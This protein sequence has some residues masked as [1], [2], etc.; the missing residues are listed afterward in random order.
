VHPHLY[1]IHPGQNCSEADQGDRQHSEAGSPGSQNRHHHQ[2]VQHTALLPWERQRP[3]SGRCETNPEE[4]E[5]A[6]E[7]SAR[8][9]KSSH[10]RLLHAWADNAEENQ[11]SY[12]SS[13]FEKKEKSR[14]KLQRQ[15]KAPVTK[16]HNL[17]WQR[18]NIGDTSEGTYLDQD[19]QRC[20]GWVAC[21]MDDL[22][23]FSNSAEDHQKHLTRLLEVLS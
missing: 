13:K 9:P 4:G 15:E 11:K 10:V 16:F 12:N 1:Q 14:E 5:A 22:I 19:N 3:Q 2:G 20:K 8:A 6:V 17:L 21:Y 23:V 18:V 7:T